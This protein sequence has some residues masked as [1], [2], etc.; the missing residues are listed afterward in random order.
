[1]ASSPFS[2]YMCNRFDFLGITLLVLLFLGLCFLALARKKYPHY[3]ITT[4]WISN[5]GQAKSP[6]RAYFT[7]FLVT[8][9][10]IGVLILWNLYV[11]F[12]LAVGRVLSSAGGVLLLTS[13]LGVAVSPMN[14]RKVE[15]S[16]FGSGLFL[17]L[18]VF[19]IIM[20][21]LP[22]S[23]LSATLFSVISL[24]LIS[25][26]LFSQYKITTSYGWDLGSLL[27]LPASEKSVFI[28]SSSLLEWMIFAVNYLFILLLS[29]TWVLNACV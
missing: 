28:R 29:A 15:H 17:S 12:E 6:S 23:G 16:F 14:T 8:V 2:D 18:M 27:D 1:M 7:L 13:L 3:S 9:G 22:L 21:V 19:N 11:S 24:A 10:L 20:C 26:F 5:L 25:A 4:H